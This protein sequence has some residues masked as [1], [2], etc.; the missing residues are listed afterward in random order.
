MRPKL[1]D[2]LATPTERSAD[3][4]DDLALARAVGANDPAALERFVQRMGC[5]PRM[6]HR[7]NERLGAP[8]DGGDV[9][10]LVQDVLIVIWRK[11][12]RFEGRSTL[13]TWVYRVCRLELMN[14][15]RRKRRRPTLMED[16]G[17][18]MPDAAPE[19]VDDAEAALRGLEA[20]GPPASDVIRWKHFDALTFDQ[21]AVRLGVSSNT[22]KT[23]Y[24][25]G[26][27]RLREQ[28]ERDETKGATP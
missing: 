2:R 16:V 21:I 18:S 4:A 28:L 1:P 15:V 20:L 7:Q 26:L 9:E 17:E 19:P 10:D 23:W 24:Y 27:C 22:A 5:V 25:R 14:G 8:M 3:H 11:L 12:D 13:E 6:L